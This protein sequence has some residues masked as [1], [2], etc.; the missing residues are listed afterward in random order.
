MQYS[1]IFVIFIL[2]FSCVMVSSNTEKNRLKRSLN[3]FFDGLFSAFSEKRS[4]NAPTSRN[5]NDHGISPLIALSKLS[6]V[7][8]QPKKADTQTEL[9]ANP[10][11]NFDSIAIK[12]PVVKNNLSAHEQDSAVNPQ[13]FAILPENEKLKRRNSKSSSNHAKETAQTFVA[14][15]STKDFV[16]SSA[17]STMEPEK[18]PTTITTVTEATIDSTLNIG[19]STDSKQDVEIQSEKCWDE[20]NKILNQK[21]NMSPKYAVALIGIPLT[22]DHH[23]SYTNN[24]DDID[25]KSKQSQAHSSLDTHKIFIPIALPA[26]INIEQPTKIVALPRYENTVFYKFFGLPLVR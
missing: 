1:K 25:S 11:Q 23:N 7:S 9:N 17:L 15:E 13:K 8:V 24:H 18:I 4:K 26:A 10:S 5:S 6:A 3:Y 2:V 19:K 20:H 12:F 16:H 22:L 14:M 21:P